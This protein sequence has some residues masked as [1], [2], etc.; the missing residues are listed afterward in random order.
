[1]KF[2]RHIGSN[3]AEVPVK[4]QS[5]RAI[6]NTNLAA[7]RLYEILRKD[8]FSDIETGPCIFET[9][10]RDTQEFSVPNQSIWRYDYPTKNR[11][12]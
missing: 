4:F 2:D 1:M 10:T 6:L 9:N 11:P 7:S 12:Y 3:A 8:V 5:D